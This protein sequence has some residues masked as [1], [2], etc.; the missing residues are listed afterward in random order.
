MGDLGKLHCSEAQ[1]GECPERSVSVRQR[2]AGGTMQ[3]VR[4]S[5]FATASRDYGQLTRCL[6][7]KSTRDLMSASGNSVIA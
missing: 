5:S 2:E 1:L 7:T 3:F 4:F 6:Q